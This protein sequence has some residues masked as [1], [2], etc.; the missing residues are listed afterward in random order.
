MPVSSFI[1]ELQ[2]HFLEGQGQ[3]E[4]AKA[5]YSSAVQLNPANADALAGFARHMA[6]HG[7]LDDAVEMSNSAV[8][9]TPDPPGWYYGVPALL[10]WRDKDYRMAIE[11]AATYAT[12]DRE[13]GPILA[14]MAGVS[15]GDSDVVN[16]Y[17]PQIL[18]APGFRAN[19]ILPHLQRRIGDP[20]LMGQIS[21]FLVQ[22]GVPRA[23]LSGPF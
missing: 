9:A 8:Y 20:V 18:E 14:V 1:W 16:R 17:L 22:A 12:A 5:A 7:D 2:A 13:I 4:A 6:L 11:D 3:A 10:A 19:G 23:A 21:D 15:S